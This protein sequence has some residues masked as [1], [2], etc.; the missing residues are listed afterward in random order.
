MR[1]WQYQNLA[2]NH[3]DSM[4]RLNDLGQEG[5]EVCGT[6]SPVVQP[7]GKGFKGQILEGLYSRDPMILLKREVSD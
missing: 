1:K 6:F 7:P 2:L 3:K 5:W 4:K